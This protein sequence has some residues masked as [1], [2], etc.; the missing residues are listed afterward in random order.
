MESLFTNKCT[1][2]EENIRE[3]I[4]A[5]QKKKFYICGIGFILIL[6]ML[7]IQELVENGLSI[8]TM[9]WF[10][11]AI[12]I[13]LMLYIVPARKAKDT[14]QRYQIIYHED[15]ESDTLF[16]EEEFLVK[17]LQAKAEQ[18]FK[19]EQ[20]VEVKETLHLYLLMFPKNMAALIE[21]GGFVNGNEKDFLRFIENKR[22]A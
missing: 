8:A 3:M 12:V 20:I 19:Y 14:Y 4:W 10:V 16:Y 1:Y 9:I 21:K 11:T 5:I 6:T 22:K 7:E 17:T 13:G 15:L 2:T 18:K